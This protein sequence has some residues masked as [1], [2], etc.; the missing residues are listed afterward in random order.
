MIGAWVADTWIKMGKPQAWQ[1]LE[2]G[3]GR[4]TLMKDMLRTLKHALPECY[5]SATITLL[6]ISPMLKILQRDMLIDHHI[7][8]VNT[9][10]EADF[11]LPTIFIANELLDAF[12]VRQFIKND[13]GTY[14]ERLITTNEEGFTF[15]TSNEVKTD[16]SY[17]TDIVETSEAMESFLCKLKDKLTNGAALFIDYGDHGTGDSLQALQSHKEINVLEN[18]GKSDITAHV[19]FD[20]VRRVLG[21]E[22]TSQM[23]PMAQFLS[24]IG[25]PLRAAAL[26][27]KATD[28][29]KV[30]IESAAYRLMH[31]EQM[32][33]LFK[34]IAYRTDENIDLAGLYFENKQESHAA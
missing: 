31:P 15:T 33:E 23:E 21:M 29:Q 1:L 11:S 34:V 19:N 3:P 25:L 7:R 8:W 28:A 10:D 16:I 9:I 30:E 24:S 12:P 27:E 17:D 18:P 20:N 26:L 14:N 6:E 2:A 13:T 22:R 4:G 32:G 5:E